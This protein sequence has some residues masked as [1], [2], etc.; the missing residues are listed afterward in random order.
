MGL[1]YSEFQHTLNLY[2]VDIQNAEEHEQLTSSSEAEEV[3]PRFSRDGRYLA[4]DTNERGNQEI[5][6]I[7]V[8]TKQRRFLTDNPA[9]DSHPDWS[10]VTDELV[11][12]SDRAGAPALWLMDVDGRNVRPIPVDAN[13]PSPFVFLDWRGD[14]PPR[15]SP[16]G[17][18]I[19]FVAQGAKGPE[20][21]TVRR[22]GSGAQ[23][24]LSGVFSFDWYGLDGRV[25][26]Y[27][28]SRPGSE[29][30]ERELRAVHLDTKKEAELLRGLYGNLIVSP[31][32]KTLACVSQH[33]HMDQQFFLLPLTPPDADGLPRA[34]GP[35]EQLT[36][37]DGLWHVQMGDFS[38]DGKYLVYDRDTDRG[39]IFLLE[40]YR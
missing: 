5:V 35:L 18:L 37:S 10:P 8:K 21:W 34:A 16:D 38:P 13:V 11:F 1:L 14:A 33:N 28:A 4:F 40:N 25:I 7:E 24:L 12:I 32:R 2:R 17:S 20:F 22:D 27:S 23:R 6:R 26:V 3:N 29:G 15:W 9:Q 39:D 19:G 31:D 30:A 36:K